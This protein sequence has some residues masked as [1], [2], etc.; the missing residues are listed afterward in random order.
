[1]RVA[2]VT[3][4]PRK[5]TEPRGGV[6]AVSVT[7]V[8]ALARQS[9]AEIHVVTV[10]PEVSAPARQECSGLCI[11]RLPRGAGSLLGFATGAGGR[12]VREYLRDLKPDLIHAHDTFGIMTRCLDLPRVFTIHGFIHEDLRYGGGWKARIVN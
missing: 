1:M 7:L 9:G 4:Y 3:W 10:D 11:H 8:R 2:F 5:P 6:E 12:M